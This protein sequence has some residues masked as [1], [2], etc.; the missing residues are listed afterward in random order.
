[1]KHFGGC[2]C[3]NMG[4]LAHRLKSYHKL[5]TNSRNVWIARELSKDPK[6]GCA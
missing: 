2:S 1:M 4:A 3:K 6:A 5:Q